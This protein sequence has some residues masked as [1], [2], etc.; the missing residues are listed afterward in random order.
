MKNNNY[1]TKDLSFDE[2]KLINGGDDLTI[3]FFYALG[4]IN[5]FGKR[6]FQDRPLTTLGA[7][8]PFE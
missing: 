4:Y 3:A 7:S 5:E 8:R 2:L 6:L 1:N